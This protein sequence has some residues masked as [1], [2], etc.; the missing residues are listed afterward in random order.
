MKI[1]NKFLAIVAFCIIFTGLSVVSCESKDVR[2]V[3]TGDVIYFDTKGLNADWNTV[4]IYFYSTWGGSDIVSWNDSLNME[5]IEGTTVFKYTVPDSLNAE[6]HNVNMLVFHNGKGGDSNQ[7]IDLGFIDT[8]YA[9]VIDGT[10]N[11]KQKGYWYLYDKS[12]LIELYNSLK[13]YEKMYYTSDTW[14]EF[15]NKLIAASNAIN[16]EI[17]LGEKEGGGYTVVYN[18]IISELNTAKNNLVVNKEL[19]KNKIDEVKQINTNGYTKTTVDTLNTTIENAEDKYNS[20]DITVDDIKTWIKNL[21][22]AAKA[23][24]VDKSELEL[25]IDLVNT[26]LNK[27]VKY[28]DPTSL[29]EMRTILS[30]SDVVV[31]DSDAT[32]ADVNNSITE[33]QDE[34]NKLKFN[35]ELIVALINKAN[36]IDFD[37]YTE[38]SVNV[39]KEKIA[40][41]EELLKQDKITIEEFDTVE[42]EVNDGINGL[43]EKTNIPATNEVVNSN[44]STGTYIV[45]VIIV[46]VIALIVLIV[47]SLYNKNNKKD[48]K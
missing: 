21:D 37:K 44:P 10:Y 22:D 42:K 16:N 27:Y 45:I 34:I 26:A 46:I 39:L 14:T 24:K 5:K 19:L 18:D 35:R 2:A 25:L 38:E 23:L 30:K 4:K 17:R 41:A 3:K 6:S 36:G 29:Q 11:N 7:T 32:V 47:T 8:G 33:I 48:K 12:E 40:K 43:V 9:Y 1:L 31:N 28:I 15:E 13:D 20:A